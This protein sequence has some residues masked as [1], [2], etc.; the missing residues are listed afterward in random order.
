MSINAFFNLIRYKS[1]LKN[2]LIFVALF[3]NYKEQ[4]KKIMD[5]HTVF[6][7]EKKVLDKSPE[8]K[9]HDVHPISFLFQK[10]TEQ[11][12]MSNIMEFKSNNNL[13]KILISIPNMLKRNSLIEQ[14]KDSDLSYALTSGWNECLE[15]DHEILITTAD[16]DQGFMIKKY[17][18]DRCCYFN[19][20]RKE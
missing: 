3:F 6:I 16:I 10:K 19:A 8:Q 7:H 4:H 14:L 13:S 11:S 20:G 9:N 12:E 15:S 1:Y 5:A 18:F 17:H 2:L